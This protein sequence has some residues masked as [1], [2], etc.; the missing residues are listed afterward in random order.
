MKMSC[1][2]GINVKNNEMTCMSRDFYDM[3]RIVKNL[4]D[5]DVIEKQHKL[6]VYV[7]QYCYR[8]LS[9]RVFNVM[10]FSTMALYQPVLHSNN[11][12]W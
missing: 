1:G 8:S 2:V 7:N 10:F 5:D 11:S 6:A 4:L 9:G 3:N 12:Y